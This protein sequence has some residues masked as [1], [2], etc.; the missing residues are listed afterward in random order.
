MDIVIHGTKGGRGIFTPNKLTGLL[1]VTSDSPSAITIGQIAYAI[2]IIE[3]NLIFSQYKIIRDVRGDK[4]TGFIGFSLFIHKSEKLKG[5]EVLQFL[6]HISNEYCVRYVKANNL[7]DVTENWD[8][9]NDVIGKYK[10]IPQLNDEYIQSGMADDAFIYFNGL[11]ELKSYFDSPFQDNYIPYRQILFISNDLKGKPEDPLNAL[12]N[13]GVDLTGKIDLENPKYTLRYNSTTKD[14]VKVSVKINNSLVRSGTKIQ[15]K[16]ELVLT[17][18]KQ[19]YKPENITGKCYE[20][21]DKY[22]SVNHETKIVTI[23]EFELD[24]D[25]KKIALKIMDREKNL[26]DDVEI[27]VVNRFESNKY[28]PNEWKKIDSKNFNLDF[29]GEDIGKSWTITARKGSNLISEQHAIDFAKDCACGVDLILNE[30]KEIEIKVFDALNG[31]IVNNFEVW[32]K[33]GN[34]YKKTTKIT[35]KN[36]DI[37]KPWS[38]TIKHNEYENE[39]IS[40]FIPAEHNTVVV[41]LKKSPKQVLQI[42]GENRVD[43]DMHNS[44]RGVKSPLYKKPAFIATIVLMSFISLIGLW[45]FKVNQKDQ[46]E[47]T[48]DKSEIISYIEGDQLNKEK[49]NEFLNNWRNKIERNAKTKN[50]LLQREKIKWYNP[51]TWFND[52]EDVENFGFESQEDSLVLKINK[53]IELRDSIDALKFEYLK[54][55]EYSS[56][57]IKFKEAIINVDRKDYELVNTRMTNIQDYTLRQIADSINAI[58]DSKAKLI[59][60]SET[61]V[62]SNESLQ[63]NKNNQTKRAETVQPENAAGNI[64]SEIKKY[65]KG[66][67]LTKKKLEEYLKQTEDEN[68]KKSIKLCMEFWGKVKANKNKEDFDKILI[69]ARGDA[70]LK[71]S[72][73]IMYLDLICRDSKSFQDRF[74]STISRIPITDKTKLNS[75]NN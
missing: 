33:Q 7:S 74:V 5:S 13:S 27:L 22:I 17:W 61:L 15:R 64:N 71:H 8:F 1:D 59:P 37:N 2:R 60:T 45:F 41:K 50:D 49:L 68:L 55:I 42:S 16:N 25:V 26:F 30:I 75:L 24:P 69:R 73:L 21:A 4:R 14:D 38:L 56:E 35:F 34:G 54:K 48:V 44:G 9:I 3:N 43:M 28:K 32:W 65:L 20:I 31:D 66:D 63:T 23:N 62:N 57:Q 67:E 19:H 6:E 47:S 40:G 39:N 11:E 29:E 52:V 12:R 36:D 51:L 46:S 10:T 72:S 18:T 53:A 70:N 58:L